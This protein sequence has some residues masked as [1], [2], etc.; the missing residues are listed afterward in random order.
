M[1]GL[2]QSTYLADAALFEEFDVNLGGTRVA[3]RVH[4]AQTSWNFFSVVGTQPVLGRGFAAGDDVDATGWGLPGRNAAAVISYGLWQQIFGADRRALGA[5]VRIDGNPLTV[6]GV[7]PRGFDFPHGAVLWKPAAFSPGNNGW[8]TVARLKPDVSWTQARAAFAVEAKRLSAKQEVP[9]DLHPSMALLQDALAGPARNASLMFMGAVVLVLLIACTNVANILTARTADRISEFSIRSA[10]GASKGRLARQLFTESV[11]L[12]LV[13]TL[14][15]FGIAYWIIALAA[16]VAPPTL[17]AQSYSV[18]DARVLAFTVSIS[19]LTA[20]TFSI[21]PSLYLGRV[22]AL[23]TRSSSRPDG[24]RMVRGMLVGTQVMLTIILLAGSVS[25]GRAF[26]DLIKTDRGYD[27]RNVVTVS[28]SGMEPPIN[29]IS[30]SFLT[31]KRYWTGFGGFREFVAQ[32][33]QY[34]FRSTHQHLSEDRLGWMDAR[35]R[36][37]QR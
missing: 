2:R 25:L 22:H 19:I 37:V 27:V 4:V 23:R 20:L 3:S 7:A 18:L 35:L 10:L 14:G 12:S 34:S 28:V 21:L 33:R 24:S 32:V 16:R 26:F 31:S 36:A 15:G 1:T 8:G 11:L 13:A 17:A 29:L 5:T 30:G 6:I 9:D